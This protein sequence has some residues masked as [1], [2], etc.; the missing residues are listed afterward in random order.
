MLVVLFKELG[1]LVNVKI[2]FDYLNIKKQLIIELLFCMS[3][4]LRLIFFIPQ[5]CPLFARGLFVQCNVFMFSLWIKRNTP[6]DRF[7]QCLPWQLLKYFYLSGDVPNVARRASLCWICL[8][9]CSQS[10]CPPSYFRY[11]FTRYSA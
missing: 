3:C 7:S 5:A 2:K 6:C 10:H 1:M 9:S 11:Y 4:T 8:F